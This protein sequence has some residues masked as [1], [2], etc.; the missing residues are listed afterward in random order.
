MRET[1]DAEFPV[2]R[3]AQERRRFINGYEQIQMYVNLRG[4]LVDGI[5]K[6]PRMISAGN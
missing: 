4:W 3:F 2:P 5:R 6:Q 1:V